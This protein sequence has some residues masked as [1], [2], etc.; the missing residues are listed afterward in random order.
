MRVS[1]FLTGCTV[2]Y[3]LDGVPSK[4]DSEV[5][6]EDE[7]VLEVDDAALNNAVTDYSRIRNVYGS[8]PYRGL[9][10]PPR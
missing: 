7:L 6:I 9:L 1:V 3:L 5:A 4:I 8:I 2:C 10:P